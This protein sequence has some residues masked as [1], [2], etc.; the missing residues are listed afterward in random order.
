M[1]PCLDVLGPCPN[2]LGP[3]P[4]VK[5]IETRRARVPTYWARVST[6]WARVSTYWARVSTYWPRSPPASGGPTCARRRAPWRSPQR[7]RETIAGF[8]CAARPRPRRARPE[9]HEPRPL[10]TTAVQCGGIDETNL[11][12]NKAPL[13]VH[14]GMAEGLS[15]FQHDPGVGIPSSAGR[16]TR[17][18]PK[19]H[20]ISQELC[21]PL[22]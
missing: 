15:D 20:S 8:A 19:P 9:L 11:G 3:C 5:R 4:D 12:T 18:I 21:S 22:P 17:K 6:Y 7:D 14:Q 16:A 1:G 2:V 13:V 10:P